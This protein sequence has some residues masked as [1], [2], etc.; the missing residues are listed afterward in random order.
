MQPKRLFILGLVALATVFAVAPVQA[1]EEGGDNKAL[2]QFVQRPQVLV[3]ALRLTAEQ[4]ATLRTL[5]SATRAAIRPIGTEIKDLS[6][7]IRAALDETSPDACA[8]GALVV[9]RYGKYEDIEALL[10]DF[11]DD[12]SAI[13]TPEQLIKYEALKDRINR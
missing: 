11:D 3:R 8:I 12:F 10:Q 7:Q 13:L 5:A 9:T 2:A 1:Q 6:E 4:T